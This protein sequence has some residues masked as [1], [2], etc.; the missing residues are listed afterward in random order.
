MVYIKKHYGEQ[1]YKNPEANQI[2]DKLEY[3]FLSEYRRMTTLVKILR[4]K[5]NG[6]TKGIWKYITVSPKYQC[7]YE[8]HK[9]KNGTEFNFPEGIKDCENL[10]GCLPGCSCD[11]LDV[12]NLKYLG[13]K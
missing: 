10:P 11:F 1:W 13:K 6:F 9:Q 5:K 8:E 12:L 4:S 3:I 2:V 7:K